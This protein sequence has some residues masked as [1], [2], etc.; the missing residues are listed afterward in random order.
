MKKRTG[1]ASSCQW[2]RIQ[3]VLLNSNDPADPDF[4]IDARR[5]KYDPGMFCGKHIFSGVILTAVG[6]GGYNRL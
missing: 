3:L 6:G 5:H 1:I 2:F 4:E